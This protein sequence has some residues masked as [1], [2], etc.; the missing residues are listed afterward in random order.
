[1]YTSNSKIHMMHQYPSFPR[2][3]ATPVNQD[4]M[5]RYAREETSPALRNR[6]ISIIAAQL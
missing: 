6:K 3:E 4:Q 2:T 5:L 1:M